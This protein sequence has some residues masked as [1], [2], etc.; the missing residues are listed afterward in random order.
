MAQRPP[1]KL[2]HPFN[3]K[4]I[5]SDETPPMPF[6]TLQTVN[7]WALYSASFISAGCFSHELASCT[8]THTSSTHCSINFSL[9][10]R[11]SC[12]HEHTD[13]A[14]THRSRASASSMLSLNHKV[15]AN[16]GS[17]SL[18]IQIKHKSPVLTHT[19]R[20]LFNAASSLLNISHPWRTFCSS[21][22]RTSFLKIG[23]FRT[24]RGFRSPFL[25]WSLLSHIW[26][27]NRLTRLSMLSPH[28][29]HHVCLNGRRDF[30]FK[31][32]ERIVWE[33]TPQ[34][35]AFHVWSR[36]LQEDTAERRLLACIID[37]NLLHGF[38]IRL[39]GWTVFLM[40]S[41]T[42]NSTSIRGTPS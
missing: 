33:S 30:F 10:F 36:V 16:G 11:H 26:N 28:I 25:S 13:K 37:K 38:F 34:V 31:R 9:Y 6:K 23:C 32:E 24:T 17:S 27:P 21:V 5:N 2:R 29:F 18:L 40:G 8:H 41:S 3:N 20:Q 14:H 39:L 7:N 42:G 15:W 19:H 12:T 35:N 1:F 4:S 22:I